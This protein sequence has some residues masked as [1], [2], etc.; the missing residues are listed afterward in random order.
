MGFDTPDLS[1]PPPITPPP[2]ATPPTMADSSVASAGARARKRAAETGAKGL[3]GT[4]K[5]SPEGLTTPAPV[6]TNKLLGS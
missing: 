4:V 5:T 2:A 6:A 1:P 3:A